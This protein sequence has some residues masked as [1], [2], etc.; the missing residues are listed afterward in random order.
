MDAQT[1]S[2]RVLVVDDEP[3]VRWSVS[4]TLSDHGFQVVESGDAQGARCAVRDATGGFDAVLLDLQLP[5]SADLSLLRT[6]RAMAPKT[7]LILM[8]AFGTPELV[9]D[10]L[11]SGAYRVLGSRS[12]STPWR[13]FSPRRP[14]L[15]RGKFLPSLR[16]NPH[17]DP[18]NSSGKPRFRRKSGTSR[19]A[20]PLPFKPA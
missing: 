20:Q 6:L 2:R 14:P 13:T 10:A 4:E 9:Q 17:I 18:L 5:D 11:H 12:K 7:A 3:L 1:N 16:I 15:R 19:L 8:T